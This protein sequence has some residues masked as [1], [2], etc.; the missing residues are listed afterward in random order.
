MWCDNFDMD[1]YKVI[2]DAK[3]IIEP[4]KGIH[5]FTHGHFYEGK[6][7]HPS[8]WNGY[9]GIMAFFGFHDPAKPGE[10]WT[11]A[12]IIE[13]T[14]EEVVR[15][16][17]CHSYIIL[18]ELRPIWSTCLLQREFE[19]IMRH[20][21]GWDKDSP[22]NIKDAKQKV[23]VSLDKACWRLQAVQRVSV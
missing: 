2:P 1:L 23:L 6:L 15:D 4:T 17:W 20:I 9:H 3:R 7:N 16:A 22:R 21:R 13:C 12:P 19:D 14:W 18:V 10:Y 8:V 11:D 5:L